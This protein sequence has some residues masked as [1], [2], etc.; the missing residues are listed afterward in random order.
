MTDLELDYLF[1][2]AESTG[3]PVLDNDLPFNPSAPDLSPC[4][5]VVMSYARLLPYLDGALRTFTLHVAARN[6]FITYWIAAFHRLSAD[7][8]RDIAIR[9]LPQYEYE[10]AAQL[11]VSPRPDVVTRVFMLFGG[12]EKKD[13]AWNEARV[14][15][16]DIEWRQVVGVKDEADDPSRF[17]V[18][19]WGGMEVPL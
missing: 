7:N 11:D 12:V 9:F 14:R 16:K 5:A 15:V 17:R 19:E 18:L 10:K 4:N 6:D 8:T 13:T 3:A 1:W 2:E